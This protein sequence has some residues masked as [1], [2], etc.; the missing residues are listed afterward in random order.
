MDEIMNNNADYDFDYYDPRNAA[1]RRIQS[2][3]NIAKCV[4][5]SLR[6]KIKKGKREA[7]ELDR[8]VEEVNVKMALKVKISFGKVLSWIESKRC[9]IEDQKKKVA[10][11]IDR[12]GES[13]DRT[14][15]RIFFEGAAETLNKFEDEVLKSLNDGASVWY[16]K[17]LLRKNFH[18]DVPL[19]NTE[20]GKERRLLGRKKRAYEE[21]KEVLSKRAVSM[22]RLAFMEEKLNNLQL[23]KL[24]EQLDRIE[25]APETTSR[26][27]PRTRSRNSPQNIDSSD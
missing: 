10:D 15:R 20:W 11:R 17:E 14:E 5:E 1:L 21:K 8:Y 26:D 2:D 27:S 7:R 3:I 23:K 13:L 12:W 6:T 16:L 22:S 19:L 25:V 18:G 9:D 24:Q 4:L